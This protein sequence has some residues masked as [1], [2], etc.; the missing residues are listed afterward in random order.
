MIIK[1]IINIKVIK[2]KTFKKVYKKVKKFFILRTK[3]FWLNFGQ[4]LDSTKKLICAL[5][6]IKSLK[7]TPD[8]TVDKIQK[9]II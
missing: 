4:I 6:Q 8:A 2:I 7:K 1:I 9:C 3:A 5:N